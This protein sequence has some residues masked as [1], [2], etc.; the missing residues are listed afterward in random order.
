MKPLLLSCL[1]LLFTQIISAQDFPFQPGHTHDLLEVKFSPDKSKLISYSHDDGIYFWDVASGR[2]LWQRRT[3]F[4]QKADEYYTLTSFA[5]SPDQNLVASGSGNG[6]VQ[7]WDAKTGRFLWRADAHKDSVTAVEFSPDGKTIVSAASPKDG[8]DEI[9]L[10]RVEDGQVIK[11]LEGKPCTVVAI[12]FADDGKLLRTGN[13]DGN[14]SEW[15]LDT[16]KQVGPAA[17]PRCERRRT[18]EW[19][20]SFNPDLSISAI[21]TGEKELTLKD[22][23]T[24]TVR[25]KIEAA[26]YRLYSRF[27]ADGTKLVVSGY[28]EFTFHDLATGETR[29][30]D[31]FS[32]TGS[33]IDLS[34][35]G[36]LFV[37]GG[38]WGDAAIRITDTKTGK[39]HLL[40]GHPSIIKTI[41][42]SPD[43]NHLAIA[44][45]DKNIYIFDAARHT[46]SKTLVGH[47][48]P[49]SFIA[50]SPD[51]KSLISSSTDGLMKVWD[52]QQGE[53]SRDIKFDRGS[54]ETR[55]IEFTVDGKY[56]LTVN[57]NA[58]RIWNAE[59][60]QPLREIKTLEGY[61]SKS[62]N[63]SIGYESVPVLTALF[64]NNGKKLLSTHVDG[65][66]RTWDFVSGKQISSFKIGGDTGFALLTP[67]EK[68]ILA[69]IGKSDEFQIKLLAA[70]D[71]KEITKFDNKNT[72]YLE[73]LSIS[74]NGKNFATSKIGGRVLLW[75]INKTRPIYELDI[76]YSGDDAIAF[77][78]DGKTLAV[79]G[80]NQ[81]LFLFDVET[82]NK[83]WQL[84]PSYQPS[85]VEI[86]LTEEKKRRQ[87]K[88]NEL[89]ARRDKQAA[90][91]TAIYK[92]QVYI[93]FEHYGDMT[94]P[95]EQR[96]MESGEPNKSKVKK[97]AR[98]A[99]AIWLR[100]HNDSPLPIE[101]P[102]RSMY[103]PN[104]KC[105]YRLQTGKKVPGLCNDRE[106]SIWFR[107]EDRDSKP[108]PYG[109]DFGSSSILLPHTSVLFAVSRE[110]LN[111]GNAIRVGFKF[112]KENDE[113]KIEDYGTD[114][115]LR[116]READ[117]P[118]GK[119]KL[120]ASKQRSAGGN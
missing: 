94:D 45:S 67:D 5:F 7:L 65:T 2:L 55:R 9:K 62:G 79:G 34:Q 93:T 97:S 26:G 77:S 57:D 8:E 107:L 68:R 81:N 41:A 88:L 106:I 18:Y 32:G 87:A 54:A 3:T 31:G 111:D 4:I 44:G 109:F 118:Q 43:G 74:P 83:L 64:T 108:L 22:T 92:K 42:Y 80:R 13:L 20:T 47:T 12:K 56:F 90:I 85:E 72:S 25:K 27:S 38:S 78:P 29:K 99:N 84:L 48:K 73:A 30:I 96:L 70:Q 16:G 66:L 21:R 19:D 91:D 61:E 120:D 33:T 6:T 39:S 95:G 10:L 14:V 89:Q 115:F 63:M 46:P 11:K 1:L 24:G 116:F 86:R 23:E 40:D 98:D 110:I 102:T 15:N 104:P 69:A 101:I 49:I 51:G 76:G 103:L 28:S 112:Q 100:L 114:I 37:E 60:W 58:L 117:L 119:S 17:A 59:S 36:S 52:W 75:G 50:F 35:D 71:G 113:N 53:F 82:G 105:F